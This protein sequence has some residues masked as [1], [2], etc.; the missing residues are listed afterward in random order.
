MDEYAGST[1]RPIDVAFVGAY[2]R[3]HQRRAKFLEAVARLSP[4][5]NVI[6]CLDRSLLAKLASTPLGFISPFRKLRFPKSIADIW[7]PPAFGRDLYSL[8]SRSKIVINAAIDMAGEDRGNM[9]CFEATGCGAVLLSDQGNYPQ[10][11]EAGVT[12]LSYDNA[13]SALHQIARAI[14]N[15]PD[16]T[17]VSRRGWETVRAVYSKERQ[18]QMFRQ[19]VANA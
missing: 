12:F 18:W 3:H 1:E 4:K 7:H 8:F 13:D 9:R 19:I 6:F 17:T 10:G 5:L 2:S 15:Y 16:V 11:F 14:D